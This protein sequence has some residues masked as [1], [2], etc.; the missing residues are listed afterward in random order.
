MDGY[1][2]VDTLTYLHI[3]YS[4]HIT[5]VQVGTLVVLTGVKKSGEIVMDWWL[6]SFFFF[7]GKKNLLKRFRYICNHV[8][9]G[10]VTVCA[11]LHLI[12]VGL[13]LIKGILQPKATD[14]IVLD[15]TTVQSR[16]Y[17]NTVKRG[18]QWLS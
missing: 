6:I 11:Q 2:D 5:Q 12:F 10:S 8:G 9:L 16:G 15:C 17:C 3:T 14:E 13:E 4:V 1:V 18:Y 7:F